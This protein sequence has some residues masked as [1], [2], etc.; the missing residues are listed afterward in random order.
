MDMES[1]DRESGLLQ[2]RRQKEYGITSFVY[3]RRRPFH[4]KRLYQLIHDSF[5]L[6]QFQDGDDGEDE[7]HGDNDQGDSSDSDADGRML[8]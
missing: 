2:S 4:S 7:D 3:R 6:C 5:V 1:W 8:R